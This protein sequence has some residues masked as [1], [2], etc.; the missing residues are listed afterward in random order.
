[1]SG[2]V[3]P[4]GM[5]YE[6]EVHVR[7][8]TIFLA[9]SSFAAIGGTG[10]AVAPPHAP[11][12]PY[13][14]RTVIHLSGDEYED[15]QNNLLNNPRD[16]KCP[17]PPDV[18]VRMGCWTWTAKPLGHGT[19]TLGQPSLDGAHL[20]WT[21]TYTNSRG[22]SLTGNVAE[23]FIPDPSPSDAITHAN[24]YP[25]TYTFT[26]GTGHFAGVSGVLI[27]TAT[28]ITVEVDRA[29]GTA[30]S[31]FASKAVGTLTFPSKL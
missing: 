25:A 15:A 26:G 5:P 2:S 22:D 31:K 23:G 16:T 20:I 6:T 11:S 4:E 21:F 27:G 7:R 8:L 12:R 18:P 19:Y 10:S 13:T 24:R 30:H 17:A 9:L 28:T 3:A 14:Y 29:T 1:M